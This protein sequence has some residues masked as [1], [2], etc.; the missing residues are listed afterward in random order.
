[1]GLSNWLELAALALT[2]AT[3]LVLW[4]VCVK[5]LKRHEGF[6]EIIKERGKPPARRNMDLDREIEHLEALLDRK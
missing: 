4:R 1:M 6:V 3:G 5:K 2:T